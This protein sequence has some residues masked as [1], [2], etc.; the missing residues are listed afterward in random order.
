MVGTVAPNV[1]GGSGQWRRSSWAEALDYIA[2]NL[3]ET[4]EAF[5]GRG[6]ALSDRG[7]FFIS[8]QTFGADGTNFHPHV[9]ALVSDGVFTREGKFRPLSTPDP[10]AFMEVFR[11]LFLQRLHDAGRLSETFMHKLLSWVHPGFSVF[12]GECLPRPRGLLRIETWTSARRESSTCGKYSKTNQT[13]KS[14]RLQRLYLYI[15][16]VFAPSCFNLSSVPRFRTAP[17]HL[18]SSDPQD[19]RAHPLTC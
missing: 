17:Q 18:G 6:I 12:A 1:R 19:F 8:L 5:G 3:Q 10:A 14:Q 15:F 11:R 13:A 4:I 9:H 2:E 7:G 16:A